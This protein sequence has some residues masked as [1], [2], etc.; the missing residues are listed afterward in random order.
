MPWRDWILTPENY[1]IKGKPVLNGW[2]T[3]REEMQILN[4]SGGQ[5]NDYYLREETSNNT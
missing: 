2:R 5:F 1:I 4:K 3:V